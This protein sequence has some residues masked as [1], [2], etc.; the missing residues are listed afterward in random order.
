MTGDGAQTAQIRMEQYNDSS[1]APD[2]RT[3]K[4]RGT[5][6]LPSKNDAGDFIYRQNSERYNGSTYTTVGQFAV[7][8]TGSADR[9]RLTLAVSEDGN[10]ID[11]ADAQFM[12]DGNNGGAIKFNDS[13]YFPT[14]DGTNG[15][16]LITNGSG[17]LSFGT[18]SNATSA[19]YAVSAS[20]VEFADNT[21][22]AVSASYAVTASYA[23]SASVE[24]IKEVSSSYADTASIA[25]S[26][27]GIFSGSFSGSFEGDG[28][29]LTGV[30]AF[31]YTGSAGIT[32]SL[33][34][35]GNA[36]IIG[37]ANFDVFATPQTASGDSII[38]DGYYAKMFGPVLVSGTVTVGVGSIL[39]VEPF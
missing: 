34:L 19:S 28:S 33:N 11:A 1:D 31:P 30:G 27:D 8:S 7:D 5:S 35:T 3:R 6:A 2:I 17:S 18:V 25:L 10:T 14:S 26:G 23:V 15:Q 24:I 29:N 32:G 4:A 13:Y 20:H 39:K 21:R 38:P 9:F 36:N 12:I 37:G 16:A 22:N